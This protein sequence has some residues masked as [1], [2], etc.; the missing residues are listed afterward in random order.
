MQHSNAFTL[1]ED[2]LGFLK[3]KGLR[4]CRRVIQGDQGPW[5]DLEG[6]RVLNLCSNN[7]LGMASHPKL[8]EAAAQAAYT[9]G[10]GSGASRLICGNMGLHEILE[11]RLATLK[12]TE[13]TVRGRGLQKPQSI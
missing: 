2:R 8:K 4:R 10:C 5:V 12:D 6:K 3:E 7:Y 11:N 1:F 13:A 9:Y